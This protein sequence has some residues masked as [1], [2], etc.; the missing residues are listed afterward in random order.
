MIPRSEFF[1]YS[2][3]L[4]CL[5]SLS[6]PTAFLRLCHCVTPVIDSETFLDKNPLGC[7]CS[8]SAVTWIIEVQYMNREPLCSLVFVTSCWMNG[9]HNRSTSGDEPFPLPFHGL[10][11]FIKHFRRHKTP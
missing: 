4:F 3:L 8:I 5:D 7:V 10:S 9:N 6:T 1:I 11:T 2:F